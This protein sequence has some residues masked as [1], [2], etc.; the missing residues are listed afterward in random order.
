MRHSSLRDRE[1]LEQK[2]QRREEQAL[3]QS[4]LRDRETPEEQLRRKQPD[5]QRKTDIRE[6]ETI[7]RLKGFLSTQYCSAKFKC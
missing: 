5:T 4:T 1:T 2:S 7:G 6:R 3:L